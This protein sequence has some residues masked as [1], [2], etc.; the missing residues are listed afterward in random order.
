MDFQQDKQQTSQIGQLSPTQG[1]QKAGDSEEQVAYQ[2]AGCNSPLSATADICENC[3]RWQME[4]QCCFCN[5]PVRHG[6]KFCNSC[7]NPPDGILCRNCNTLSRFDI[8]PAC[9]TPL[10]KRS[11]AFLKAMEQSPEMAEIKKLAEALHTKTTAKQNSP[12]STQPPAYKKYVST[13][14]GPVSAKNYEDQIKQSEENL[15]ASR[16]P[17]AGPEV[18]RDALIRKIEEMQARV[19]TDNQSARMF[20]TSIK[21]LVPVIVKTKKP[22]GWKCNF[23]S[24]VHPEGPS[25]CG[26]PSH[27]GR[28]IYDEDHYVMKVE[29]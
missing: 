12:A 13:F 19:F 1:K 2:C 5:S 9:D 10:S 3:G 20:Y 7:G 16:E 25:A 18:D 27:G 26:D 17:D 4:G 11:A 22:I 24:V 14:T 21:I 6:Q 23:A 8:C 29:I 28:W 15:N